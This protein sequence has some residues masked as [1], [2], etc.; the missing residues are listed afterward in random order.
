MYDR[1]FIGEM[2][3][4]EIY[5]RKGHLNQRKF[6]K[7]LRQAAFNDTIIFILYCDKKTLMKRYKIRG[8]KKNKNIVNNMN[9]INNKFIE[10]GKK[11]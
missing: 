10:I 9:I 6:E 2:I 1:H 4:P 3:Y 8:R 11:Y 5:K 7:L